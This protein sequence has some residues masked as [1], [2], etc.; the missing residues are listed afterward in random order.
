M[1]T[2]VAAFAMF[3]AVLAIT[4]GLDTMLVVRTAAGTG[5]PAGLAAVAGIALGCLVW[6][7][8]GALGVTAVLTASRFAFEV[9]RIA[10][11][12]Y[13]CWLGARALW[14][15]RRRPC[16]DGEADSTVEA[17][18]SIPAAF[19]TGLITNLLNPKVGVFYLS[20]MPQFLPEGL[21][22]MLGSLA[23]GGIHVAEGI[24]WLTLV[25][26]VG[27]PGSGLAP[28]ARAYGGGWSSSR[29]W[30]SWDSA[31]AWPSSGR[32]ADDSGRCAVATVALQV[33]LPARG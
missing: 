17:Q 6:A 22:P 9:L 27:G 23:L 18:P 1:W 15:A 19:R 11:V 33:A 7:V 21:N 3:A 26:A 13:L 16:P 4:P 25:V 8:A 20:V 10:G 14:H 5:R 12:A 2:S 30:C 24:V 29:A 32:R 31:C 28:A